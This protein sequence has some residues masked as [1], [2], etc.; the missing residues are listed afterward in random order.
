MVT[1]RPGSALIQ[2]A[3]KAAR[4]T[5]SRNVFAAPCANTTMSVSSLRI[6]SENLEHPAKIHHLAFGDP[7][8]TWIVQDDVLHHGATE[9]E[10]PSGPASS[11]K[12]AWPF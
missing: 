8:G 6:C 11:P 3:L 1:S 10:A 2:L 4:C 12:S 7:A 5:A 9:G